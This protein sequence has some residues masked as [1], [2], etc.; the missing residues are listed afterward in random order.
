MGHKFAE[1]AVLGK[2]SVDVRSLATSTAMLKDG[3]N[4]FMAV[5]RALGAEQEGRRVAD[6]DTRSTG[7]SASV[8]PLKG[9]LA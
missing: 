6:L 5:A 4:L 9:S 3:T 7:R 8:G 2:A 1:D